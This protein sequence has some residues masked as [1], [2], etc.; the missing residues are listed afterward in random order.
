MK[1]QCR[2]YLNLTRRQNKKQE[3]NIFV[4]QII[5]CD[6]ISDEYEGRL[7]LNEKV[8]SKVRIRLKFKEV[9]SWFGFT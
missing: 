7:L 1:I 5:S 6:A 8:F 9:I 2:L 3:K 4:E